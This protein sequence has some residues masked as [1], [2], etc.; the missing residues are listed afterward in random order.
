M[1]LVNVIAMLIGVMAMVTRMASMVVAIAL[2]AVVFAGF[3]V[4]ASQLTTLLVIGA[5][6]VVSLIEQRFASPER[7]HAGERSLVFLNGPRT[8]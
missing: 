2:S 1:L 8:S 4:M 5:A 7:R 3:G 6:F